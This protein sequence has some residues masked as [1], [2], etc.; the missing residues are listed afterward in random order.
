MLDALNHP[1]VFLLAI[2]VG[3]RAVWALLGMVFSKLGLTSAAAFFGAA[4]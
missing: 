2:A 1:V 3:V 4:A